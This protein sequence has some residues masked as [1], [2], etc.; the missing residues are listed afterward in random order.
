MRAKSSNLLYHYALI[1]CIGIT[2]LLGQT[3]KL[4]MHIQHEENYSSNVSNQILDVHIASSL[5]D[6]T[7]VSDHGGSHHSHHVAE[8][9]IS[10]DS[11]VKKIDSQ[12][13]LLILFFIVSTLLYR[14][15]AVRIARPG[16]VE[17]V[18]TT[19]FYLL[20]PPLRAPPR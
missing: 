3:F 14:Q 6:T 15:H 17:S 11:L 8:V 12:T 13:L 18:P 20:H 7:P 10:S 19:S 4:H 1:A 2:L 16:I 5:H 9:D